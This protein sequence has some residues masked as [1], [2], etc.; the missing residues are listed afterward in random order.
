MKTSSKLASLRRRILTLGY[1]IKILSAQNII[2]ENIICLFIVSLLSYDIFQIVLGDF[3]L[4]YSILSLSSLWIHMLCLSD[5]GRY[6][7]IYGYC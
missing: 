6:E 5:D 7:H 3:N 4:L 2:V 1:R